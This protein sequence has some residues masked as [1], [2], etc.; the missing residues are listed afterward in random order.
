[1]NEATS[2]IG[3]V[4]M[5]MMEARQRP[6]KNSTTTITKMKASNT[7]SVRL[8]MLLTMKS[9]VSMMTF[10]LTSAGRVFCRTGSC[11]C[12]FLAISTVLAP[13]CFWMTTVAERTPLVKL[14]CVRSSSVSFTAATSLM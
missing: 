11:A 2:E 5:M 7:V 9:D 1:M 8:L 13:D 4:M 12:T 14:S 3:M 6:R 10:N